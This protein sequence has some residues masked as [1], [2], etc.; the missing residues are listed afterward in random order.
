MK[1]KPVDRVAVFGHNNLV[2]GFPFTFVGRHPKYLG[3][4][5]TSDGDRDLSEKTALNLICLLLHEVGRFREHQ[6]FGGHRTKQQP[7]NTAHSAF[8]RKA[9]PD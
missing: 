8:A 1:G 2:I 5:L 4:I 7:Q 3:I 6:Q 9:L